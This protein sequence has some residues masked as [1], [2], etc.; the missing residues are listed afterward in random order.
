[1]LAG[2]PD[3]GARNT[4]EQI[5]TGRVRATPHP[6]FP[7]DRSD[8]DEIACRAGEELGVP[9]SLAWYPGS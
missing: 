1:M 9:K 2:N 7:E 5:Y 8:E 6:D 4:R 3:A